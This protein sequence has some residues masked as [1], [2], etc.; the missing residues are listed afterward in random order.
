MP[1][2]FPVRRQKGRR[3]VRKLIELT[4]EEFQGLADGSAHTNALNNRTRPA[5]I[6]EVARI[7]E[8]EKMQW[9]V[10]RYLKKIL[11][12]GRKYVSEVVWWDVDFGPAHREM[13]IIAVARGKPV[14][15]R[16]LRDYLGESWADKA[17]KA[18]Y[19]KYIAAQCEGKSM[20]PPAWVSR[21]QAD[22]APGLRVAPL[23]P[24][25]VA[26][27]EAMSQKAG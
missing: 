16:V 2:G 27:L 20:M 1:S 23:T 5:P 12:P 13:I 18:G 8:L 3:L 26:E 17:W 25:R 11:C 14:P 9:A 4:R 22:A 7:M 19:C 15:P 10:R 6:S 21:M 24:E